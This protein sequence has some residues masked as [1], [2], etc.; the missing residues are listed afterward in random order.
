M[1]VSGNIY[2]LDKSDGKVLWR[3]RVDLGNTLGTSSGICVDNGVIYAGSS[4]IVTALDIENGNEKWSVNRDKGENSPAEFIVAQNKLLVNSHWDALAALSI[5]DGGRQ[6]DNDDENIRFRSSTPV[7]IDDETI[8]VADDN[9]IMLVNA[10]NGDIVSKTSFDEYQF[11]SSAQPAYR[12]GVA[13]IP[14]ANEG[15]VAFDVNSKKILWNFK[16]G[17]SILFTAPYVGKGSKTVESSPVLDGNN[18]IFGANDGY[19]YIVNLETGKPVKKNF[20]GSAVLGKVAVAD[21]KIY[22]GT[23]DGYVVCF[24]K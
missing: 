11:S 24:N 12:D 15:M 20:A 21:S 10:S 2:C 18:I 17:E 1:D 23:F 7:I 13:Y 6:W 14:T 19:I 5:E 16:T 9:A 3:N 4:R 22:A 8:L